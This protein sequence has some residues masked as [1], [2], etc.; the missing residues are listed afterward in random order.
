MFIRLLYDGNN[1]NGN[2]M[3]V[4]ANDVFHSEEFTGQDQTGWATVAGGYLELIARFISNTCVYIFAAF[5]TIVCVVD[6]VIIPFPIVGQF[7]ATKVPIQLF[8]NEAAEVAGVTFTPSGEN[9]SSGGMGGSSNS[10]GNA[11]GDTKSKYKTYLIERSKALIFSGVLMFMTYTGIL[12]VLL[13]KAIDFIVG[14]FV[15]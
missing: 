3:S 2:G 5:L 12:S 9:G 14:F 4:N 15:E 7:F 1:S 8:S 13:N 10:S 6:A 11:N